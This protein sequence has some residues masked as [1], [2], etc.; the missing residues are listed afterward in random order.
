MM[1][2]QLEENLKI[3]LQYHNKLNPKLWMGNK[4]KPEVRKTLVNFAYTWAEFAN[5]KKNL[6]KDII[7]TGGNSN[8]NYTSKSDIDVH[9]VVDRNKLGANRSVVDDYLQSKKML[10]TLT[11]DVKVYGYSIEP[12]AQDQTEKFPVG[13][14]TYSLLKN[15]WLQEP[16]HGNYNFN[17]DQHLKNKVSYYIKMIDHMISSKMGIDVFD[18]LKNKLKNMRSSGI[19]KGG[20]FSIENLVFKE[21]RNRGY[22]NKMDKYEKTF[23]DKQL[24]LFK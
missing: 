23:K 1:V 12:Y 5:I 21:L 24:S 15:E 17:K 11:H 2:S 18:K 20:E 9:I 13:Q 19:E 10:W 3:S 7:M 4:L 14:G 8:Y 6:I 16:K 22:L